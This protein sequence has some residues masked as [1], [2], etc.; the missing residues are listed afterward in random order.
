MSLTSKI[1]SSTSLASALS[2][3]V[4]YSWL[5]CRRLV[6]T[7]GFLHTISSYLVMDTK[8]IPIL[9]YASLLR[10]TNISSLPWSAPPSPS[11]VLLSLLLYAPSSYDST[12]S[13][14]SQGDLTSFSTNL[15]LLSPI[16]SLDTLFLTLCLFVDL[17]SSMLLSSIDISPI[18]LPLL[19]YLNRFLNSTLLT[20]R[21]TLLLLCSYGSILFSPYLISFPHIFIPPSH[22]GFMLPSYWDPCASSPSPQRAF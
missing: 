22:W 19:F 10:T 13:L 8:E 12:P 1:S 2:F 15:L 11:F 9:S 16:S 6:Q 21:S 5:K 14:V 7:R 20:L 18:S 17:S 4:L 3:S